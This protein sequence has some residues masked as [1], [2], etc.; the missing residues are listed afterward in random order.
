MEAIIIAALGGILASALSGIIGNRADAA[1]SAAFKTLVERIRKGGKPV[2]HDLEKLVFRSF[3]LALRYI[4]KECLKELKPKEQPEAARWLRDKKASL[5]DQLK[6]VDKVEY[7]DPP[8]EVLSEIELLLTPE[9]ELSKGRIQAVKGKLIEAATKDGEPPSCYERK[10]HEGLFERMCA[11]FAFELKYNE[12]VRSI[13]EEQL[14]AQIAVKLQGQQVTVEHIEGSLRQMAKDVPQVLKMLDEI[15]IAI[16][17]GFGKIDAHLEQVTTLLKT[18]AKRIEDVRKQVTARQ[19]GTK[20]EVPAKSETKQ[21]T[22]IP[23]QSSLIRL[24]KSFTGR[25]DLRRFIFWGTQTSLIL[26]TIKAF[27]SYRAIE[28]VILFRAKWKND[29]WIIITANRR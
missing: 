13:F 27:E 26:G 24:S 12:V 22:E 25:E 23:N 9:G 8:N 17:G 4:C 19:P 1:V 21:W 7:L 5:E 11:Y 20:L 29:D 14:L 2:N 6:K 3:I 10:M 28:T 18:T 15:G 16:Y